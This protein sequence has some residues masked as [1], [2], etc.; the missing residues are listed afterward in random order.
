MLLAVP[1]P[2][3]T[4]GELNEIYV[5]LMQAVATTRQCQ[6]MHREMEAQQKMAQRASLTPEQ[7]RAATNPAHV[8]PSGQRFE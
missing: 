4:S 8:Y 6:R 5:V 7:I 3:Y 2:S 1:W